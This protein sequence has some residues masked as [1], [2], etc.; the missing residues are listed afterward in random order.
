MLKIKMATIINNSIIHWQKEQDYKI[1]KEG[2]TLNVG[3][4]KMKSK[5]TIDNIEVKKQQTN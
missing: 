1:I 4:N 5:K 2:K 3:L